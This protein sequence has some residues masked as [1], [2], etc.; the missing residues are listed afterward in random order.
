MSTSLTAMYW[1]IYSGICGMQEN[2]SVAEDPAQYSLLTLPSPGVV[3]GDRFREIY[4]WDSYWILQGLLVSGMN[5]TAKVA[6]SPCMC[7]CVCGWKCA[8]VSVCVP[9]C[10]SACTPVCLSIHICA[11]MYVRVHVRTCLPARMTLAA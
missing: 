5:D 8:G 9:G 2:A 4:Y 11:C 3:A 6:Y 7:A 1:L 10:F